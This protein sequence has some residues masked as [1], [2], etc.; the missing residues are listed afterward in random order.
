MASVQELVAAGEKMGLKAESL[1]AFVREQQTFAKELATAKLEQ[2][3]EERAKDRDLVREKE[4]IVLQKEKLRVELEF[5][6]LELE[7]KREDRNVPVVRK[8]PYGQ[9][10]DGNTSASPNAP[11]EENDNV[12]ETGSRI[13]HPRFKIRGPKLPMFNEDRDDI[14]AFLYRFEKAARMNQW[15]EPAWVVWLSNLLTGKALEV[16]GRIARSDELEYKTLKEALLKRYNKT[17]EGYKQKFYTSKDETGESP[18]HFIARL[19][20]C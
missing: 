12:S 6:K 16:Y 17:E 15:E 4:E 7:M 2:D 9:T 14:D 13:G 5:R 19:D 3:R 18:Q 10:E 20:H 1:H 8:T 11:E